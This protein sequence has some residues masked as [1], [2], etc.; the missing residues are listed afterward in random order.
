[1]DATLKQEISY[2]ASA[3]IHIFNNTLISEAARKIIRVKGVYQPGRGQNYSGFYYDQLKDEM[4]DACISLIV[5][6]IIRPELEPGKM[7]ECHAYVTKKVQVN[8]ARIELQLTLIDLLAQNDSR[9]T[10]DEIEGFKILQHKASY[11]YRDVDSF[12]KTKIINGEPIRVIILHGISAII[13]HDIRH[14][15]EEAISFYDFDF[16]GINLTSEESIIKA[17]N[18]HHNSADILVISRGGGENQHIFNKPAIAKAALV[19]SAH[20]VTAIGHQQDSSLLQR[21]A[22]KHFITPTALGQYFNEVYNRTMEELQSSKAKLVTDITTQ[23]EANYGLKI[24]LLEQEIKQKGEAHQKQ[25]ESTIALYKKEIDLWK[26]QVGA[27]ISQHRQQMDN[28]KYFYNE[29]LKQYENSKGITLVHW[30]L[31]VAECVFG[32]LLGKGCS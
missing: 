29:K 1:M 15:L 31:I 5:P 18:D 19:L 21:V 30:I 16:K 28:L 14:Q 22:D 4:S 2:N 9:F 26:Q 10:D 17:L 27:E 23:L 20:F 32:I 12:V 13:Q 25:E 8:N 11:G 7:V 6:A 24:K 3:I